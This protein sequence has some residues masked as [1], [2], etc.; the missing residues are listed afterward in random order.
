MYSVQV[1]SLETIIN[2]EVLWRSTITLKISH[3]NK[4]DHEFA[5]NYSVTDALSA[6][7]LHSLV[8]VMSATINNNTVTTN[9]QETLPLLLRM[10]DPEEF[11]KYSSMSPTAL[12]FLAYYEDAVEEMS[13][14]IDRASHAARPE[15]PPTPY[16][17]LPGPDDVE[18]AAAAERGFRPSAYISDPKKSYPTT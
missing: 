1:P 12:D 5:V 2:G 15:L 14:Q 9:V 18:P 4:P 10:V 13:Y 6:F 17:Y 3:P 16:I 7:P 8:N 11:A